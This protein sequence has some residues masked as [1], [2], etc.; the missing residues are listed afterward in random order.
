MLKILIS[1]AFSRK[2]FN[3]GIFH[4]SS[5]FVSN[6][7]NHRIG[8]SIKYL[9]LLLGLGLLIPSETSSLERPSIRDLILRTEKSEGL[10]KGI[11]SA[12]A[13]VES[14]HNPKAFVRHDGRGRRS[15][16]GLFQVQLQAARQVGFKGTARELMKPE[17]NTKYAAKYLKYLLK[18]TKNNYAEAITAY[19]SGLNNRKSSSPYVGKVLNA[20]VN[21]R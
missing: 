12:I 18:V 13:Y 2:I 21:H 6:F 3:V 11:L 5:S 10:P 14:R 20:W 19:N 1:I 16:H 15:S 7:S 8:V 9:Y 4:S 17:V